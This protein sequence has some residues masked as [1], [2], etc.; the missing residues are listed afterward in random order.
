MGNLALEAEAD[1]IGNFSHKT[2]HISNNDLMKARFQILNVQNVQFLCCV[3]C[4]C[5][6][7]MKKTEPSVHHKSLKM[8]TSEGPKSQTGSHKSLLSH[9]SLQNILLRWDLFYV[10][11]V[12]YRFISCLC[13]ENQCAPQS[14]TVHHCNQSSLSR[15]SASARRLF[16]LRL[17]CPWRKVSLEAY[18]KKKKKYQGGW[19]N[20]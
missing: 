15:A 13:L 7:V 17:R 2:E 3:F 20:T 8:K 11:L 5:T 18:S 16:Q 6:T 12:L 19:N 10:H 4:R 9:S 1:L 14:L